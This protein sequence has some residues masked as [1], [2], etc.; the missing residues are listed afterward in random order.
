MQKP[1]LRFSFSGAGFLGAYHLG[2]ATVFRRA[3]ILHHPSG[4]ELA[5]A[6][7]GA[8]VAATLITDTPIE[9]AK[10]VLK[11]L[12][13]RTRAQPLGTVTPG[14]SLVDQVREACAEHLPVD[15]HHRASGK[16]FVALTSLPEK[17]DLGTTYHRSTFASRDELI[18]SVAAS[19]DIP[20]ITSNARASSSK[21]V[22]QPQ[23][24]F[25]QRLLGR[26]DVDGGL[27]DLFPDPWA[28]TLDDSEVRPPVFFV[29][30]FLGKGFAISPGHDARA[31]HIPSWSPIAASKNGRTIDLS[32][33]NASLAPCLLPT[34]ARGDASVRNGGNA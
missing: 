18:E 30:P 33:R 17:E 8:I 19:A 27:I 10:E 25:A 14:Y 20:C 11:F 7:A 32:A 2:V 15:A 13:E 5:G 34:L 9:R 23:T 21:V 6:S 22:S 31:I 1:P 29:S 26:D 3:G 4:I 24:S 28:E 12:V 16:L